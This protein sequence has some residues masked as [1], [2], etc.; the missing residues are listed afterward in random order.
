M[1]MHMLIASCIH[2]LD[3]PSHHHSGLLV[4]MSIAC[5]PTLLPHLAIH[6]TP[7]HALPK[8][9]GPYPPS[10]ATKIHA[11]HAASIVIPPRHP[12]QAYFDAQA[13]VI[14][15]HW[16][17]FWS[18][19]ALFDFY[20][21]RRYLQAVRAKNEATRAEMNEEA[22]RALQLQRQVRAGKGLEACGRVTYSAE[23]KTMQKRHIPGNM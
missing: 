10:H 21:R 1:M 23:P 19:K 17:G 2:A 13:T 15:R 8:F 22:E 16:R 11:A 14:Q 6:R 4:G 3:K 18:R 5:T 7:K 12:P 20:A 9:Q